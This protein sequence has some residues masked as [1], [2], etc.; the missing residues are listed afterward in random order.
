MAV[1]S[2]IDIE[3]NDSA[4]TSFYEK[5]LEYKQELENLPA[6]WNESGS[7]LKETAD[8]LTNMSKS[9]I[10]LAKINKDIIENQKKITLE[11]SKTEIQMVKLNRTARQFDLSIK[12]TTMSLMKWAGLTSVFTGLAGY[13]TFSG[14]E[15]LGS[16]ASGQRATAIGLGV[17]PGELKAAETT[18]GTR[19]PGASNIL[20]S[21]AA[22]Q[23]DVRNYWKLQ[24]LGFSR[25]EIESKNAAELLPEVLS[26][27]AARISA[28]PTGLRGSQLQALGFT[29]LGINVNVARQLEFLRRTGELEQLGKKYPGAVRDLS[30]SAKETEP[31]ANFMENMNKAASKI[32][33]TF[34]K[35][36][37]PLALSI[38]EVAYSFAD[39]SETIFSSPDFKSGIH[40]FSDWIHSLS[41]DLKKPE[42]KDI[43]K[44]YVKEMGEVIKGLGR[45]ASW[46]SKWFPSQE[47][48]AKSEEEIRKQYEGNSESDKPTPFMDWFNG[49]LKRSDDIYK[50]SL[51]PGLLHQTSYRGISGTPGGTSYSRGLFSSLE[52]QYGLP[53][54]LLDSVWSA[55]SGRGA[56]M[57]SSAGAMGH[58]QFMP[59][60]ARQYGLQNP[61]DLVQSAN[62]AARYYS[63]LLAMFGGDPEK[64]VAAYNW[65]QGNLQRDIREHGARWRDFLPQE[66]AQYIAK[67]FGGGSQYGSGY[68]NVDVNVH[69]YQ[70][71]GS[72][73]VIN[74]NQLKQRS[75][76][77]YNS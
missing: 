74:A 76:A 53:T 73:T 22:I 40:E 11:F 23:G 77:R 27:S 25:E 7:A 33:N 39:L 15:R 63:D 65:G 35:G 50:N 60:T 18:Y 9:M 8:S 69:V 26:R 3:V 2:V 16:S 58:F 41:E 66:T 56:S 24:Q 44:E 47:E 34:V 5:F 46:L 20:S 32:E 14:L 4:F 62:A 28:I 30:L 43:I 72:N 75:T 1:K 61:Y 71:P 48:V 37:S 57:M 55:E 13:F 54:G 64:A 67:V 12:S 59:G 10:D 68:S 49:F 51:F 36:L 52:S 70:E 6:L 31:W 38:S 17:A 45:F 19:L 42:T 21:I 29:D